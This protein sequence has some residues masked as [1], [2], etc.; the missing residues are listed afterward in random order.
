M[1]HATSI[2]VSMISNGSLHFENGTQWLPLR[3]FAIIQ[4]LSFYNLCT[5]VISRF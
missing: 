2:S 5:F 1:L 3:S 4:K